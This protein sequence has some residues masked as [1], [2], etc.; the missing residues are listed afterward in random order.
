MAVDPRGRLVV[1]ANDLIQKSRFSLSLQQQR[2][3]L[4]LISLISEGDYS[5]KEYEFDLNDFCMLCGIDYKNGK[6]HI[7]LKNALQAISD[8]SVWVDIDGEETLVRWLEKPKI[9]RKTRR[10][11]VRLDSDMMPFLLQLRRNFTSY[12]LRWTLKFR[13]KFSI[14][15]YE[16][17]KSLHYKELEPYDY[18]LSLN[19]LKER[20]DATGYTTWQDFKTRALHPAIQEIN[21]YS[22]KRVSYTPIKRASRSVNYVSLHMESKD[23]DERIRLACDLGDV[24]L[25]GLKAALP[26]G[27][28][29]DDFEDIDDDDY[30]A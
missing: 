17:V 8:K 28:D 23:V 26:D 16:L 21:E 2:I 22:D 19:D 18:V 25:E 3:V 29:P 1:K 6:N 30:S 27:S 14:R 15:L 4:F 11:K 24:G 10:I 12:E 20:M 9:N 7:N 13:S 5:F